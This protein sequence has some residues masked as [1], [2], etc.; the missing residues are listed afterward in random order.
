MSL[1]ERERITLLMIHGY[2]DRIRSLEEVRRLFNYT[3][4]ERDPISRS[5]VSRTIQRF[6]ETGSIKDRPRS[7]R[8]QIATDEETSVDILQSFVEDPHT[9]VKS[10]ASQLE[11]SC[12]SVRTVLKRNHFKGYKMHLVHELCE[13]DFDRRLEFCEL[14]MN[15][16]NRDRNL[17]YKIVFTDE[18]TF[19]LNGVVNRHNYRYWSDENPHWMVEKHTQHPQ[20]LNVWAG[21]FGSQVVGPFFIEGN[22]NAVQY[23]AMLRNQIIPALQNIAGDN[24]GTLWFQQ[25]GAPPHFGLDVRQH[26][27]HVFPGKWIGRRGAIEWPARSPDLSP[28]DYYFWGYLKDQVY[29]TKPRDLVELRLRIEQE[30]ARIPVEAINNALSAFYHRLGY[31]QEAEGKQFEHLL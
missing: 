20:K 10:V 29:R 2:G 15:S 30:S 5:T 3:F 26:L 28:L 6:E 12:G 22:L 9:S 11:I 7:G 17:Q 18:A 13:D 21:I 25:D 8:P 19:M 16:I 14:M 31:C 1:S 23:L 24:F 27:N 4:P